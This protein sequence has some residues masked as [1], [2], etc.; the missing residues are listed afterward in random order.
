MLVLS[1]QLRSAKKAGYLKI[2]LPTSMR[3]ECEWFYV[4]NLDDSALCFTGREPMSM[5]D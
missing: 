3:Y 5:D 2:A 1:F 4:K